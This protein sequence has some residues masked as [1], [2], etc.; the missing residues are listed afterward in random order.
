MGIAILIKIKTNKKTLSWFQLWYILKLFRKSEREKVKDI[1]WT[2]TK[3]AVTER[4]KTDWEK[5]WK[6]NCSRSEKQNYFSKR[7]EKKHFVYNYRSS[8]NNQ[9]GLF[10]PFISLFWKFKPQRQWKHCILQR[11]FY[12]ERINE[13]LS[14]LCFISEM[15]ILQSYIF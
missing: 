12:F 11:Y 1:F 8:T 13:K 7:K 6:G 14:S 10:S 9:F 4:F 2:E 15:T 3:W 5:N